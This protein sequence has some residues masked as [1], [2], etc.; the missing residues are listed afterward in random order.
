MLYVLGAETLSLLHVARL[1]H[2][3]VPLLRAMP[4]YGATAELVAIKTLP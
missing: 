3:Q 1:P 4:R 2:L